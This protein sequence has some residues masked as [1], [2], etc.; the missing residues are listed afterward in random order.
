MGITTSHSE[1]SGAQVAGRPLVFGHRGASGYRPE[2][3]LQAFELAFEQGADAIECDLVPTKD[4]QLILRHESALSDTTNVASLPEFASRRRDGHFDGDTMND[5]FCEDFTLAEI[6]TLFTR[7][8]LPESR[9]GSAKFDGEFRVPTVDDLLAADFAAGKTLIL[10]V[11]HGH[12]FAE[13]GLDP[14]PMLAAVL[15]KSDFAAR[16][17]H[18]IFETFDLQ[19]LTDLKAACGAIGKYVFLTERDRLPIENKN[20]VSALLDELAGNFDGVSV[21]LALLFNEVSDSNPEA[22]FGQPNDLVAQA[23]KRGLAIYAWTAR[24]EDAK[25]SIEEYYSAIIETNV[26]GIFADQPDLLRDVVV[27]RA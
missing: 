23:H 21:D 11:K 12:H 9:S 5:W 19:V 25:Y 26:D 4:G 27:G 8:R 6:Q 7:E 1:G 24:A 2:N 17:I 20:I 3:T 16:G 14:V 15:A 10:E 22:Q 13:L 18:V